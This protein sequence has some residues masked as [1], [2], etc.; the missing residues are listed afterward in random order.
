MDVRSDDRWNGFTR[1]LETCVPCA[2]ASSR[3]AIRSLCA[4]GASLLC[5]YESER[6]LEGAG[7]L[8]ADEVGIA[9]SALTPPGR[10]PRVA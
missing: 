4:L 10:R 7:P 2:S 6:L 5:L 3:R 8:A 1:H 9:V